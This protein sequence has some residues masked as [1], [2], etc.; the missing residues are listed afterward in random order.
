M[1]ERRCIAYT[2]PSLILGRVCFMLLRARKLILLVIIIAIAGLA[3]GWWNRHD[4][5]AAESEVEGFMRT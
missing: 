1:L 4:V 3:Y 5:A 2:A